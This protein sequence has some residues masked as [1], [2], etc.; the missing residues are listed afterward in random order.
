[1]KLF[2]EDM[3]KIDIISTL[4]CLIPFI[5]GICVYSIMPDQMPIHFNVSGEPDNYAGKTMVLFGLPAF[6]LVIHLICIIVLEADVRRQNA[7]PALQILSR[8]LVPVL[9]I[10]VTIV[11]VLFSMGKAVD[12]SSI[13][14]ALVAIM[15][16][17]IGVYL[18]KC[19][20]N[21]TV[22]IKLPWTLA[23]E[24][25]WDRTHRMAGTVWV[26]C[27]VLSMVSILSGEP[28]AMIVY[29]VAAVI[30]PVIYSF[31]LAHKKND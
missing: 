21:Y 30:V 13:L 12:V 16:T 26:V 31:R 29:I 17:V 9:D 20:H 28:Q 5:I 2:K 23:D 18:P 24:E 15:V 11:I 7:G 22:G 25:N 19:K 4:L 1:M 14:S 27:G 10:A 8:F 6:F 3:R